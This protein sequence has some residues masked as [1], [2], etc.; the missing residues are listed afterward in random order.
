M[1]GI[2]TQRA[3][4]VDLLLSLP[5]QM[6]VLEGQMA[7]W[8][9][10]AAAHEAWAIDATKAT[11]FLEGRQWTD[12]ELRILKTEGRP[13]ITKN[14]IAP[15][16]RLLL[17]L[18]RQNK[19]DAKF[20]PG[21]DGTGTKDVADALTAL[22]KQTSEINQSEWNDAQVFQDGISTGRGFFDERL[23]FDY[24]IFG[25]VK[26]TVV[27][28][29]SVY[30]DAE[31][32]S[33]DPDDWNDVTV[34]RWMSP[35]DIY[36]LYGKLGVDIIRSVG[37][38]PVADGYG[39]EDPIVGHSPSRNFGGF[40]ELFN[41]DYRGINYTY[42]AF[43]HVNRN[44]KL[45]RV[46]DCQHRELKRVKTFIDL[47]TGE[48]KVIPENFSR[49]K[50]MRIMQWASMRGL[51][52][53]VRD[54]IKKAVRWTVTVGDRTL[55]DQWSIYDHLTIVPYFPYFRRGKTRGVID[56][57]I[58]PQVEINKRASSYLHIIMTTANSGWLMQENSMEEDMERALEEEGS[59]PGINIKY[60]KGFEPPSR[61]TPAAPPSGFREMVIDATLDLKEISG[62]N[63]SALGQIDKVQSGR[64]I[65]ARQKQAVLGA[66][67]YFD[68][69]SRTR[70]LKARQ[71][72]S[73]YQ[74]YYTEERI[75][76]ARAGD[77]ETQLYV[78]TKDAAG[79]IVND[80]T[81]G[82]YQIAIDEAPMSSTFLQGQF[83]EAQELREM[84]VPIPDDVMV[85]LSSMPNK[86]DVKARLEEQR[87][88]M[89]DQAM[90]G[91]TQGRLSMGIPPG[92]PLP[93]IPNTPVTT[94]AGAVPP[95]PQPTP[96]GAL[97][98][99]AAPG[100]NAPMPPQPPMIGQ[101]PAPM[102][103]PPP[104]IGPDGMPL[105]GAPV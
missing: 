81:V 67:T 85:D 42:D 80:I 86:E 91:A 31:A 27:D 100:G 68:N 71:R 3:T 58:D 70:Q 15:L 14:K 87:A 61:I 39:M 96:A 74:N 72:L 5:Q 19:Y 9:K 48:E 76:V 98:P 60:K 25:D 75:V 105:M 11:L 99:G 102:A 21:N 10:N 101:P 22:D 92:A 28:P 94:P 56:D 79:Q 20:L 34:N 33:Y 44:R 12:E 83:Q 50:I 41:V 45:L 38:F 55:H 17:G 43:H 57:L 30:I 40:E 82:R 36:L 64:A 54:T 88:I 89:N 69:F 1:V 6:E 78:N 8:Q 26:E 62:I 66:E 90:L 53:D 104:L 37:G 59:R 77:R 46:L 4:E 23:G 32:D 93:P 16:V 35:T 2:I 18:F 7:R 84:G 49:E 97:P 51:P 65:Q 24:N 103:P 95:F 73:I 29:F 52:I 63:D 13:C 47:E